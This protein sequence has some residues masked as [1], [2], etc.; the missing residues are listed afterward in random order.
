M[1]RD[2]EVL[3]CGAGPVGLSLAAQLDAMGVPF[4]IIEKNLRRSERSKALVLWGRSLELLNLCMDSH[5]FQVTGRPVRKA[6]IFE[7]GK[8]IAEIDFS[9][10][11]GEFGTGV[12]LPQSDT[13]RLLEEHLTQRGRSVR[14]G[15]ELVA[16]E[17]QDQGVRCQL[18]DGNGFDEQLT[19]R[20][21]VGCDGAHSV[22]RHTLGMAFPGKKDCHRWVLADV[23]LEG[24]LPDSDVAAFWSRDGVLLLFHFGDD[25]WRVVAEESMN[26]PDA[27][28]RDPSLDEIVGLM[29]Q[30]GAKGIQAREPSW[31]SE[32]R[33]HERKVEHYRRGNV[34]L[35]GDAAHVHSPAGGQGMNTGIQD[36]CNLA[37]KIAWSVRGM[38]GN[39]LL[40]SYSDERSRVGAM[41]VRTT[42][43]V[44]RMVTTESRLLQRLRN[45]IAKIAFHFEWVQDLARKNLAEF[46]IAYR[47]SVLN[48][49]DSRKHHGGPRC[50]DRVPDVSWV[51]ARGQSRTLYQ[52]LSGGR[53]ALL[54]LNLSAADGCDGWPVSDDNRSASVVAVD[55]VLSS[56]STETAGLTGQPCATP[57]GFIEAAAL[58]CLGL[59]DKEW[60][61][62]RP[63]GYLAAAGTT[64]D[65]QSAAE[66]LSRVS[67]A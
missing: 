60:L 43:H 41:V 5:V 23:R 3:I 56:D 59:R 49:N 52:Q 17:Q 30:R 48:G 37:W 42:S 16:F 18:T 25:L 66:W 31:L 22:V 14:R 8:E 2:V 28:R 35:A 6:K 54:T 40:E 63:D 46:T 44:T 21:L 57:G 53:A 26:D 39:A 13:E 7:E 29:Q 62:V 32:F 24:E 33:I 34:F 61:V 10:T 64:Q 11:E 15:V 47:G 50:G 38:G 36:A 20:Y 55:L 19:V 4:M 45:M 51:D 1:T 65:C 9:S 27:P 12:L 58:E 67:Q